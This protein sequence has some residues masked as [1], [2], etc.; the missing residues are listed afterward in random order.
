VVVGATRVLGH[1]PVFANRGMV[2][3]TCVVSADK[4]VDSW[5]GLVSHTEQF[6]DSG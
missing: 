5:D 3:S 6:D 4:L 1:V 2:H